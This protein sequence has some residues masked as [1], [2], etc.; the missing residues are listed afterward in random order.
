MRS[1]GS[2]SGAGAGIAEGVEAATGLTAGKDGSAA[3][4]REKRKKEAINTAAAAIARAGAQR[5]AIGF[6]LAVKTAS[7]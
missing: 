5:K 7:Q 3:C 6:V 1:A 2:G 4:L